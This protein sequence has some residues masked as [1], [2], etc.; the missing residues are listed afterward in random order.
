MKYYSEEE[1]KDLRLA[2]ED[3]V[4]N[5]AR[6]SKKKMFGCPCYKVDEKLFA[7]LVTKGVVIT[8]L[9]EN[10]R[11][12]ITTQYQTTPFQA[13]KKVVQN[14]I[15][16]AIENKSD[17]DKIMPFVRKSYGN[18]VQEAKDAQTS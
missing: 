18:T 14:W 7:F 9:A 11:E 8:K 5:W 3:I 17:I 1:T 13:G 10:E 15:R 16:I 4:L 2:F 12:A 6:V